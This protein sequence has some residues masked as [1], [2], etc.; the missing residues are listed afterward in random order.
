MAADATRLPS[1]AAIRDGVVL[2]PEDRRGHGLC[3]ILPMY[4]NIAM[5]TMR[6]FL[7]ALGLSR[8]SEIEHADTM[9]RASEHQARRRAG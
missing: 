3:M 2:I 1:A 9:I 7:G 5:A 6:R 8:S 4:E